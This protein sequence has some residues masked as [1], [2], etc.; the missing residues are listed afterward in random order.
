MAA[1]AATIREACRVAIRNPP[2]GFI[3][4]ASVAEKAYSQT[5]IKHGNRAAREDGI[6]DK[7]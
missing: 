1:S 7:F 2:K 3:V 6:P 5:L 4:P